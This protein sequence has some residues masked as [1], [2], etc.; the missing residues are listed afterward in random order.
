M[1]IESIIP[2]F[3]HAAYQKFSSLKTDE[4]KAKFWNELAMENADIA[5]EIIEQQWLKGIHLL[6]EH[7]D[8]LHLKVNAQLPA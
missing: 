4:E 1:K 3:F 7:L 2:E 5:P 8:N 6:S